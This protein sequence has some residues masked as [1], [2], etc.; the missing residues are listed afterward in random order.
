MTVLVRLA[1]TVFLLT[2][3]LMAGIISFY[4][5]DGTV[6]VTFPDPVGSGGDG[7]N[8]QAASAFDYGPMTAGGEDI[9]LTGFRPG[10]FIDILTATGDLADTITIYQLAGCSV[11]GYWC[12]FG[13]E[14]NATSG[15]TPYDPDS[16]DCAAAGCFSITADGTLQ[17]AFD[18][19]FVNPTTGAHL[20]MD[21]IQ[22]QSVQS[23]EPASIGLL[24]V[25]ILAL[26]FNL[27]RS[28]NLQTEPLP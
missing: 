6:S 17:T 4:D 19:S 13:V 7:V 3:P 26:V 12:G 10:Y 23:P 16:S 20:G 2:T 14:F 9:P 21:T 28:F 22:F 1:L 15:Q 24:G 8:G 27:H 5:I 18:V 25:G 11:N